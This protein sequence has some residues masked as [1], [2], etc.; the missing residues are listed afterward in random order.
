MSETALATG[1]GVV[2]EKDWPRK[3]RPTEEAPQLVCAQWDYCSWSQDSWSN[4]L[5]FFKG[6][7]SCKIPSSGWAAPVALVV[8]NLPDKAGDARNVGSFPG[9]GRFPDGGHGNPLQYFAWRIPQTKEPG[10]LQSMGL[11]R[12]GHNWRNLAHTSGYDIGHLQVMWTKKIYIYICCIS[13]IFLLSIGFLCQ[14]VSKSCFE[15]G[16]LSRGLK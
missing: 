8:K 1:H 3:P 2:N 10:G 14:V 11:Q 13:M 5:Y 6:P 16:A 4:W 15:H 12:V 9:S 7:K